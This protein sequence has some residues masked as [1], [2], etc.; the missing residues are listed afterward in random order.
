MSRFVAYTS[1][2]CCAGCGKVMEKQGV[3]F[4]ITYS[5]AY[6]AVYLLSVLPFCL[7]YFLSDFLYL[8]TYHVVRYRRSVVKDNLL[9]SFPEKLPRERKMIEKKFY[10]F[11]C[12]YFVETFKLA[13]IS[14]KEMK[15]RI[16]F[17]GLDDAV[18]LY[19]EEGCNFIFL[20]LG[21]YCNWEWVST[22]PAHLPAYVHGGQ[23]YH[24]L[25]NKVFDKIFLKLRGRFGGENIAMKHTLRRVVNLQETKTPA[26][27]GFISDQLPK[28]QNIHLFVPF[29]HRQTAVFTGAEQMGKRVNATY[30][31]V[32]IKRLKRGFYS[33]DFL[34]MHA[35]DEAGNGFPVTTKFMNLL[36]HSIKENPQYWLWTHKRWKRTEEQWE[37]RQKMETNNLK[38]KE[39]E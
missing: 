4:R 24:P 28:W 36:E 18:R 21:H 11:L 35:D 14:E 31:Y 2:A 38:L 9:H 17:H 29:L 16:I 37:Q 15:K 7:L 3:G 26:M 34:R 27:I 39:Y 19:K 33:C 25:Y 5:V 20:Y 6:G 30:F 23:I 1:A 13:S 10:H 8:F 22:I 12:D 32:D